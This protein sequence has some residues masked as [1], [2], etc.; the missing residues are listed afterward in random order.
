MVGS[1]VTG[2]HFQIYL[3][4]IDMLMNHIHTYT[5]APGEGADNKFIKRIRSKQ[6]IKSIRE[7]KSMSPDSAVRT[8]SKNCQNRAF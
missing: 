6:I 1:K 4:K 5:F 2:N 3:Y 8:E 7:N